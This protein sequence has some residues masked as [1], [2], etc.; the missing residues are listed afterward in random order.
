MF[1]PVYYYYA[2][3]TQMKENVF[4]FVTLYFI[5]LLFRNILLYS[6]T[7][8]ELMI[9]SQKFIFQVGF[10]LTTKAYKQNLPM[11]INVISVMNKVTT[12]KMNFTGLFDNFSYRPENYETLK[13]APE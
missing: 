9:Q 4:N 6:H 8:R 10:G 11:S 7:H 2:V 1:E 13:N 3:H 12:Y 5:N